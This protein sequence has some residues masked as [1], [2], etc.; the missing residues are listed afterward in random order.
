MSACSLPQSACAGTC[1]RDA[2]PLALG[3]RALLTSVGDVLQH[4]L[5]L[6]LCPTRELF[7]G[8]AR[9]ARHLLFE[10]PHNRVRPEIAWSVVAR[11][12]EWTLGVGEPWHSDR[13]T[14]GPHTR[15]CG[16][17]LFYKGI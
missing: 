12:G 1:C 6:L 14:Y 9:R 4:P 11:C 2:S 10:I 17:L 15:V 3:L 8:C 13:Q 7:P 5:H 16:E